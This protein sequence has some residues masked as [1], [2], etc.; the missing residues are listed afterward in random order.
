MLVPMQMCALSHLRTQSILQKGPKFYN[1]NEVC[2]TVAANC[3]N[4]AGL[5][6]K[7]AAPPY[8]NTPKM[9]PIS[10]R[11]EQDLERKEH[12]NSSHAIKFVTISVVIHRY[13]LKRK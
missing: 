5:G 13:S 6:I 9:W 10:C 11:K 4:L 1:I 2:N 3:C 8:F 12:K 7:N